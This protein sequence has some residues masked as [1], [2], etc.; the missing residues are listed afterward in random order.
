MLRTDGWF[1]L[2][3]ATY[4]CFRCRH[5]D[6]VGRLIACGFHNREF[7]KATKCREF[8]DTETVEI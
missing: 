3:D 8:V 4:Q 7:P 2:E 5:K 1:K 6:Q